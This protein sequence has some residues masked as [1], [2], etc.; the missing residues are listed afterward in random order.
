MEIK[1]A[2]II[3][4]AKIEMLDSLVDVHEEAFPGFFL[5]E[6]GRGFLR[7]YYRT[8]VQFNGARVYSVTASRQL[9]G[10]VGGYMSSAM[11]CAELRRRWL[12]FVVP[13]AIGIRR[14]PVLLRRV[15]ARVFN[16]LQGRTGD[17]P[18]GGSLGCWELS[19]VAVRK[20]DRSAGLGR[21]LVEHF[22]AE[23][24]RENAAGVKLYTDAVAN[25]G[26][27]IFYE[28]IGFQRIATVGSR[29]KM[30]VYRYLF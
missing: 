26:V 30:N 4:E 1:P 13:V 28:R 15:A 29:R 17:E 18:G 27:N 21:L 8:L 24:S 11:F 2:R 3:T 23:A 10:F 20:D 19:S 7:E 14:K 6:V 5:T 16:V 22:L 9:G 12:K 25:D